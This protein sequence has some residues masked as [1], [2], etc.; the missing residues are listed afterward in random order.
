[1][2]ATRHRAFLGVASFALSIALVVVLV[3]LSKIDLRVTLQQLRA[4][5]LV[6]FTKLVL[7]TGFH[8]FLSNL[9]WRT[10]DAAVRHSSDSAPSRVT[11]FALTSAGIAFGQVLPFQLST[12]AARTLGTYFHRRALKRGTVGTLFEQSFDLLIVGLLAVASTVTWLCKGGAMMWT[13]LAAIVTALALLGVGPGI[14]LIRSLGAHALRATSSQNRVLQHFVAL[15]H[16]GF[17]NSRLARRLI[18]VSAMRFVVQVL[19]GAQVA[20]AIG[21][22]VPIWQL[23]AALPFAVIVSVLPLTPGG[24]GVS[25]LSVATALSLFGTPLVVGAQ[26]AVANRILVA[27][28]CFVVAGCAAAL[29]GLEALKHRKEREEILT[30]A[31][32]SGLVPPSGEA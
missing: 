27:T 9:K 21:V 12:S 18:V 11:S 7:M 23:A 15:Q 1:M 5:S 20:E 16:S 2:K 31:G 24:I 19:M 30:S 3:K 13:A 8:I 10:V 22:S 26:W 29:L 17:L 25:E 4:V 32:S 6:A 14:Q 28:S